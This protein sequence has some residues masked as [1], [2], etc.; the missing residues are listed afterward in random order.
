MAKQMIS[1]YW[2]LETM[3]AADQLVAAKRSAT[4][5]NVTRTEVVEDLV[6]KAAANLKQIVA[7]KNGNRTIGWDMFYGDFHVGYVD[8]V[9]SKPQAE[10][11]LNSWVREEL[12]K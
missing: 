1:M 11:Q 10:L 9:A 2:G 6:K 4:N 8:G 3:I 12:S 5:Q 7:R